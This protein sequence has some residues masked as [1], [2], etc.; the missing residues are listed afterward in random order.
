MDAVA[1][2]DISSREHIIELV[3]TFYDKV[4]KDE[5]IGHIFHDIIGAD[6]SHHLPIMYDF[7]TTILLHTA[8][9]SGNPV[10]KH[11]D[12]DK[13]IR[14]EEKHYKRWQELWNETVD[15]LFQG[16]VAE[17]AKKRA[18]LMIQL[19]DMKVQWAREG[20]AIQ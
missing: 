3:N 16:A 14:L 17:E 12:I 9:Y 7:W 15:A 10:K 20:K 13:R 18:A 5:T 8:A 4:K 2:N 11:I 1:N 19:I 6:W